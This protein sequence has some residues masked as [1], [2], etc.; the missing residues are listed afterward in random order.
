MHQK[1]FRFIRELYQSIDV[2]P[3]YVPLFSGYESRYIQQTIDSKCVSSVVAHVER[4]EK[5]IAD[6]YQSPKAVAVVNET[7]ALH[8]ADVKAGDLVI[9]QALTVIATCNSIH[10][11]GAE[12]LFVNVSTFNPNLSEDHLMVR[13][14][15]DEFAKFAVRR[16]SY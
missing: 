7:A 3:L 16:A 12:P 9:A 10:W 8:A 13:R 14:A 4:F 11:L 5:D 15:S 2:I 6:Y 1:M